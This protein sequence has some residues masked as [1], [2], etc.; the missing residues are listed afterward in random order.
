[1]KLNL[2]IDVILNDVIE[3]KYI[4]SNKENKITL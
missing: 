1:M 2:L 3:I 4:K